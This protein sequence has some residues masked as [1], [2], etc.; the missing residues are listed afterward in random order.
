MGRPRFRSRGPP[1]IDTSAHPM[2]ACSTL[3]ALSVSVGE[4]CGC[5]VQHASPLRHLPLSGAG[6][7]DVRALGPRGGE[8]R[9][10][11]PSVGGAARR[12]PTTRPLPVP[13][14]EGRE[15]SPPESRVRRPRRGPLPRARH[16]NERREDRPRPAIATAEHIPDRSHDHMCEGRSMTPRDPISTTA[17]RRRPGGVACVRS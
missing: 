5:A 2:S 17:S 11:W 15:L 8:R 10:S 12:R 7:C 9:C 6:S 16:R 1:L 3:K 4:R 13:P 14:N